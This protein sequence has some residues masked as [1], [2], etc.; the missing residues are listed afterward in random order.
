M[1]NKLL[2]T[3]VSNFG[4]ECTT[5]FSNSIIHN[6]LLL[7]TIPLAGLS[8]IIQ[9]IFGLQSLTIVAFVVLVTL[10]L[11]TGLLAS[12]SRGESI[13]SRKFGRF[14]FKILVWLILIYVINAMRLEYTNTGTNFDSLASGFFTWLHGTLFI[15]VVIEYLI[16]VLENLGS[17]TGGKKDN[18]IKSIIGKLNDFLKK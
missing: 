15:Y 4:F 14:G 3:L 16:S 10:E 5:D 8:S 12:L 2:N 18:L 7:L 17:I 6:K 1:I 13:V 11:I 9:N